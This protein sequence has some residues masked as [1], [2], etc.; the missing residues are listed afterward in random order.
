MEQHDLRP[1][2]ALPRRGFLSRLSTAA[3]GLLTAG[4]ATGAGPAAAQHVSTRPSRTL[5]PEPWLERLD[6]EH[7]QIFDAASLGGGKALQQAR[8]YLDAY[9]DAYGLESDVIDAV[10]GAHGGAVPL[11]FQDA[12]WEKFGL[13]ERF[14]V[15]DL[16]TGAPARR[17][18]FARPE[19]GGVV[20]PDASVTALQERGVIFLLCNNSLKRLTATLS[21]AGFGAQEALRAELLEGLLP[22]VEVVPAM[23]VALNLAQEKGLSYVYSG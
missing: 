14:D 19:K 22:G 12:V 8:N 3:A 17:N 9:R 11:V 23:V 2:A 1:P 18:V 7:G 20:P 21:Q 16:R 6:G 5:P 4:V 15:Q 10:I 13:G